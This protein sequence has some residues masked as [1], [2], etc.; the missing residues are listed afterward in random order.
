MS[1]HWSL[2]CVDCG[3]SHDF[4]DTNHRQR[5][6]QDLCGHAHAIGACAALGRAIEP[7]AELRVDAGSSL[8]L[9]VAW[10][11]RHAAHRLVPVD[12]YGRL[13][14]E[15]R[16]WGVHDATCR[17]PDGHAGDHAWRRLGACGALIES[18]GTCQL[19]DGHAGTHAVTPENTPPS[20]DAPLSD[21]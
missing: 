4:G 20:D 11:E 17:L 18:G 8:R 12:E 13:L 9:D 1:L 19:D 3:S 21:G 5:L 7:F 14:G 2:R 6:M 16:T 15:C 10:F